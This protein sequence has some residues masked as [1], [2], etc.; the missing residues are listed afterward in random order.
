MD[1]KEST[2][3]GDQVD[4]HWYYRAKAAALL[5]T[6]SE[7]PIKEILDVGAGSGFFSRFLLT[8]TTAARA[9]CVDP[10]YEADSDAQCCGKPLAFRRAIERN[11]ADTVLLMDVLEH[12]DDEAQ[13]LRPYI[14]SVGRDTRFIITVPAFQFLWSS[15]D[16]Y[17]EHRRRYTISQLA[18]TVERCG[19]AL[20]CCHYYFALVFPLAAAARLLEHA[21]R[22]PDAAPRSQLRREPWLVNSA[23]TVLCAI[24]RPFMRFNRMF[25]LSIFCVCRKR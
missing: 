18:A 3:L 8:H 14:E 19:L 15:H 24:E 23:L 25:G 2:I 13:L 22:S 1:I 10:A 11:D 9:V 4:A 21:L 16:V 6:I 20:E 5:R 7:R 12:V 17:L